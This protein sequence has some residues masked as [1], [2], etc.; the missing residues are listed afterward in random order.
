MAE[1]EHRTDE[2]PEL[3]QIDI[4]RLLAK[5]W[6][7]FGKTWWL[8]LLLLALSVGLQLGYQH[9]FH[10]DEYEAYASF[11][12]SVGSA[13]SGMS[14]YNTRVSLTK[15]GETFPFIL[16][17]GAL[18]TVIREELGLNELPVTIS[19]KVVS[20]TS[21]FRISVRGRD[22]ELCA[23]ILDAVIENYP[24]VAKYVIGKTTLTMLDYSGTPSQ[25]INSAG[26]RVLVVRGLEIGALLYLGVLALMIVTRKTVESEEDLKRYT[27]LRC[28]A[29]IPRTFLKRR[30]GK[31]QPK[32]LVNQ[33]SVSQAFIES[34]NLLRIRV[35]REM[36]RR[37]AKVLLLTSAG[38]LEGKSTVSAN[39]ALS[40]AQKGFRILLID[41]DLR[42]PS[43]AAKFGLETKRGTADVL[44]G[45]SQVEDVLQHYRGTTLDILPGAGVVKATEVPQLLSRV[46]A[47]E[48]IAY[49]RK[50]YDYV[51]VD[52]P[53]CGVM[54]DALML[55][56][57]CDATVAVIRQDFLARSR[58]LEV[59][60]LLAE[61][62]AGILGCVINGEEG[63]VGSYG[64]GRYGYGSGYGKYG[65]YGKYGYGSK[66][67][68]KKTS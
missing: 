35:L 54:Q 57:H 19:A 14:N 65:A 64:Y 18:K 37:E 10:V 61:S 68:K 67:T 36:D 52:S 21:L 9:F 44:A 49:G 1:S 11:S 50:H 22:P 27:S 2:S 8:L 28:L 51:I 25:P 12:V 41:G 24:Q 33:K 48:L 31:R 56:T 23:R 7:H 39:L 29:T 60:D 20:D 59:L 15:L 38:E 5:A 40:C 53:P 13:S 3:Q 17:S 34:I 4:T 46:E 45:R 62:N 16:E 66:Y 6:K 43:V 30:S 32:L 47:G 42:H 63:K 58:I 26:R 55:A